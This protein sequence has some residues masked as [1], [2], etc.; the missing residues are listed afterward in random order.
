MHTIV[1]LDLFLSVANSCSISKAST[2]FV[3]D[4]FLGGLDHKFDCF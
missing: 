4:A 2:G 1:K 3:V